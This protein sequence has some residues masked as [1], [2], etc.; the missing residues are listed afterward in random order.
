M[1]ALYLALALTLPLGAHAQSL[2]L[3]PHKFF[4]KNLAGPTLIK[5]RVP[6]IPM[7]GWD[8]SVVRPSDPK[9]RK[10][11]RGLRLGTPAFGG[12]ERPE[13]GTRRR[14]TSDGLFLT[15]GSILVP[16]VGR[17]VRFVGAS[18]EARVQPYAKLSVG[19]LGGYLALPKT[20]GRSRLTGTP[21]A[22]ARV[23]VYVGRNFL[24]EAGYQ[25][26]GRMQGVNL[27]SHTLRFGLRI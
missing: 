23:G 14:N 18:P 25:S 9:V 1:K 16:L 27:S 10:E 4:S 13:Q 24:V 7:M 2:V 12:I 3:S 20:L 19:Y 17:E 15:N 8:Q 11:L 5:L 6:H 26:L 22:A 21:Q